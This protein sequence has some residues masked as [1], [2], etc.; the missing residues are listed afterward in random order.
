MK[1][2][3]AMTLRANDRVVYTEDVVMRLVDA[4]HD[5]ATLDDVDAHGSLA[6]RELHVEMVVE[7]TD[8]DTAHETGEAAVRAAL[9]EMHAHV[10]D[11]VDNGSFR[12]T[13]TGVRELAAI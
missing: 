13:S 2:V 4:L 1:F 7:A 3:I 11:D 9:A 10:L 8:I 5:V 6:S 12:K